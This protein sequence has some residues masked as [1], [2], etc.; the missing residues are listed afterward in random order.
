M[1]NVKHKTFNNK[2]MKYPN[3]PEEI[4]IVSSVVWIYR[5]KA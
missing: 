3:E 1:Y 4:N 5:N 2:A